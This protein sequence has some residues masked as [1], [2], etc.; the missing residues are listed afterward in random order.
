MATLGKTA[1]GNSAFKNFNNQFAHITVCSIFSDSLDHFE[2]EHILTTA[3]LR[4][5]MSEEG[6]RW[7]KLTRLRSGGTTLERSWLQE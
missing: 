1:G 6:W 5:R 2:L 7:Q 4:I 3:L